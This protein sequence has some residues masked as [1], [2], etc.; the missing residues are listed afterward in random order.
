MLCG[1][2]TANCSLFHQIIGQ[3]VRDS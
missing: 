1:R 2:G 3:D